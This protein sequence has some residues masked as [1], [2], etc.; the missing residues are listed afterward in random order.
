MLRT[1]RD[2]TT[3]LQI[4]DM[5]AEHWRRGAAPSNCIATTTTGTLDPAG[6]FAGNVRNNSVCCFSDCDC[7]INWAYLSALIMNRQVINAIIIYSK[8]NKYEGPRISD[9]E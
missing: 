8:H 9:C 6:P 4:T 3:S 5:T 7:M 2:R 1:R